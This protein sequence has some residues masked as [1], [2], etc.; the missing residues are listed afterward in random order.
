MTNIE[1]SEVYLA[2]LVNEWVNTLPGLRIWPTPTFP[3]QHYAVTL[4]GMYVEN[5]SVV[6]ATAMAL[7]FVNDWQVKYAAEQIFTELRAKQRSWLDATYDHATLVA[8]ATTT[9]YAVVAPDAVAPAD[10]LR[11]IELETTT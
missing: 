6:T 9:T 1:Q 11:G 10:P 5:G 7:P 8:F 2:P 3:D 4:R